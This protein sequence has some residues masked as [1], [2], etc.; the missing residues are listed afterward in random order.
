MVSTIRRYE[1][2]DAEWE[3]LSPTFRKNKKPAPGEGLLQI[4]GKCSMESAGFSE[5]ELPGGIFLNDTALGK[6]CINGS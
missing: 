6:P 4:P 3:R 2:T 1:L 5:V